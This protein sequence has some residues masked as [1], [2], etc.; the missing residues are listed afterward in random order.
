MSILQRWQNG[1][2]A[3]VTA[4]LLVACGGGGGS[5][6]S[7]S[8]PN[9]TPTPTPIVPVVPGAPG[10][11]GDI[12]TDG[13]N[14][15]NFRRGQVG[16]SVLT[17]SALIDSA[18]R[19]HSDYQR[20]NNTVVHDEV[21]G[22]AGFTGATP[23]ERLQH[24]GYFFS[25]SYAYGEVISA[26]TSSSGQYLAEELITAI[27]H[28]FVIFEPKFKEIGAG[29]A[30]NGSGY[31]YFTTNFAASNGF[32]PGIGNGGIVSWPVD[33][34]TGV[35]RNF[36]SDFESPD[37]VAGANEVGYPVSVHADIDVVLSVTSFTIHPHGGANLGVKLL[38]H[39]PT[40][41]HTPDSA[42][43]IVPLTVLA[44]STTYDVNF[45]GTSNG[46]PISKAWSF[47]TAP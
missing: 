35:T 7:S 29:S 36:F 46:T 23:L 34:Q 31:T 15:L 26:S 19:N 33:G 38:A 6:Y 27:Y 25:G 44:G 42:A 30:S 39:G 5:S 43:A 13:L 28:R 10:V 8:T 1:S 24:V 21:A 20:I 16:I 41:Q 17:R 12:A 22:K 2:A 9:P 45:S 4:C 18:A 14:W 47:T 11:T 40:D 37:P 3:L 32:G